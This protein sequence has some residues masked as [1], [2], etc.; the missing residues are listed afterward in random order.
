MDD[1]IKNIIEEVHSAD[2]VPGTPAY[3]MGK[4]NWDVLRREQQWDWFCKNKVKEIKVKPDPSFLLDNNSILRRVVKL[5]YTVELT[6]VIPRKLTSL[7][8]VE[9]PNA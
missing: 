7:I 1:V 2:I 3:N 9:F 4:L 8:I 6:V 5:K